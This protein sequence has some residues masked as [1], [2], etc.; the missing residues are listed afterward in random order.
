MNV[1]RIDHLCQFPAGEDYRAV[2]DTTLRLTACLAIEDQV[3]QPLPETSPTKWHLAHTT[4]FFE[5]FCLREHVR[6]YESPDDRYDYLFNSYYHTAGEIHPRSR[7]GSLSRPTVAEVRDYRARVDDAMQT[8]LRERGDDPTIALRVALGL[9][10][11]QQH[12]ELLLTDVKQVLFANPLGPAY[13]SLPRP[14]PR[15]AAP[16]ELLRRTGGLARIGATGEA[17]CFDNEMPRHR[18]L[19]DDH[20]L[21]SRLV[22]NGDYREFMRADGYRTPSLWLADGWAKLAE[23]GW[24]RPL[25]WS[26]DLA[27][28][29]TLGG[30]REIDDAA[31]VCHV[32]FYEADAFA[33]WAGAR[34]PSEAEWEVSAAAADMGGNLLERGLLHPAAAATSDTSPAQLFGDV[35]EWCASAYVPYPGFVPFAGSLGEYNGKFMCNQFV[36]RGGSCVTPAE[37]IRPTYRSFFYP[38]DRWQ[39]LGFRLAKDVGAP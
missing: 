8:L 10:H 11:E 36:V 3:V 21:G 33:R 6:G 7:R 1:E 12:Q 22:T 26:G 29:F 25:C 37:H 13:D 18:V 32:S 27:R 31:P 16:M 23:L 2:R 19:V 24:N 20:A 28:E 5:R 15:I 35:W 17:F 9:N 34:L 39:F 38:H 30:W 14:P 4:W